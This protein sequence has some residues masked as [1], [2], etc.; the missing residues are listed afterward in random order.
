MDSMNGERQRTD[1]WLQEHAVVF[2][3]VAHLNE[4]MQACNDDAKFFDEHLRTREMKAESRAQLA[5][6]QQSIFPGLVEAQ[7]QVPYE[8]LGRRLDETEY[9]LGQLAVRRQEAEGED[10]QAVH[11][12][13][14]DVMV[15]GTR[16]PAMAESM[17]AKIEDMLASRRRAQ[18]DEIEHAESAAESTHAKLREVLKEVGMI[19]LPT[20][21][22]VAPEPYKQLIDGAS[23]VVEI[24]T[25]V[26]GAVTEK[27]NQE[28]EAPV[29]V[30]L[31]EFVHGIPPET[32]AMDEESATPSLDTAVAAERV[33]DDRAAVVDET[34]Q[35]REMQGEVDD[36]LDKGHVVLA[37][38]IHGHG[39]TELE[40]SPGVV[41]STCLPVENSEEE[42][43]RSSPGWRVGQYLAEHRGELVLD[44]DIA[45]AVYGSH[46]IRS[47]HM[48]RSL[49]ANA[50]RHASN[51]LNE[52]LQQD[53]LTLRREKEKVERP[54]G[55]GRRGQR[56]RYYLGTFSSQQVDER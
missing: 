33:S 29:E 10:M 7:G 30:Q 41:G 1:D 28:Y 2:D 35:A 53:G 26:H 15:I 56:S 31:D 22:F 11:D 19:A 21:S 44:E 37:D 3:G 25:D 9:S 39:P 55:V 32:S 16:R 34:E 54:M 24:G 49:A 48:V 23:S 18:L 13:Q 51:P 20:L 14:A 38:D 36:V 40:A 43:H 17:R 50:E 42:M 12:L 27:V 52:R 6:M 4:E 46:D 8:E 5:N 47:I 45:E